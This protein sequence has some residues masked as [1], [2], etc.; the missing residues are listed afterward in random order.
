VEDAGSS[1]WRGVSFQVS[2]FTYFLRATS[3]GDGQVRAGRSL[4]FDI[5]EN[6]LKK[7]E[8]VRQSSYAKNRTSSQAG[9]G[10]VDL[11]VCRYRVWQ[12]AL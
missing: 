7:E 9:G 2:R 11:Y 8:L 10:W 4:C 5:A 6:F 12:K 1:E 3:A